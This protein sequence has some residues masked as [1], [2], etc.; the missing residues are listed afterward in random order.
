MNDSDSYNCPKQNTP[1][2]EH[3]FVDFML[4]RPCSDE[5]SDS[6]EG[7]PTAVFSYHCANIDM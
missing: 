5:Y 3:C 4:P 6:E 1:L 7:Q 2:Q